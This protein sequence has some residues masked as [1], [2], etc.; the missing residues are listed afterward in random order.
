MLTVPLAVIIATK[1]R[2][3]SIEKYALASL[4]RSAFRDFICVVWD[5]SDDDRTR[6]TA[7]GGGWSFP[8]RYFKAPR[9]G[10]TSQRNDAMDYVLEH[11]PSARYVLFIDDDSELSRDALE[12]VLRTF[13]DEG[14]WG[15]NVPYAPVL[16]G[17]G[18]EGQEIRRR[19]RASSSKSRVMTSYL[20]NRGT[21]PESNDIDVDWIVSCLHNSLQGSWFYCR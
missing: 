1:N 3:E 15:V 19:A 14:V 6:E 5:A 16:G 7:E 20:H 4:E 12:G 10:L 9:S 2:S 8:L 11:I 13:G 21:C 18:S 17:D